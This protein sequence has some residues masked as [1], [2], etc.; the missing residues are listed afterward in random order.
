[1]SIKIGQTELPHAVVLAPMSGITDRPFRQIV[2]GLGGGLLV[3]EMI[4]SHAVLHTVRSEM[5][6]LRF[7]AREESPISIQLAGWEPEV[8]AEAARIAA[9]LGA[10]FIDINLG[11]PAKKVTGR[12]SG[13]ALMREP[14]LVGRICLAVV[15]AVAVPVTLKM[16]LGWAAAH[17]TAPQ[18]ASIAW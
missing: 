12:L 13:S 17:L 7:S 8:M 1:M 11:C 16:R 2:R 18:I 14:L 6:K 15:A 10:D 9:D 3:S 5:R 4:A